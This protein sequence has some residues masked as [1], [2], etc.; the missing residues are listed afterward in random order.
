MLVDKP[1][2]TPRCPSRAGELGAPQHG[3]DGDT[4]YPWSVLYTLMLESTNVSAPAIRGQSEG[5]ED[6]TCAGCTGR[7]NSRHIALHYVEPGVSFRLAY[8]N[9]GI[10]YMDWSGRTLTWT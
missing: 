9:M 6:Q 4:A 1:C 2:R 8:R 10:K 5:R 7:G 3:P